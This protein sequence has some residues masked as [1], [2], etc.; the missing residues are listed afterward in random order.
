M[1][2]SPAQPDFV[3]LNVQHVG[4]LVAHRSQHGDSCPLLTQQPP[5]ST[6]FVPV[7]IESR[8]ATTVAGQ[9]STLVNHC[10]PQS[11]RPNIRHR[12]DRHPVCIVII[13]FRYMRCSWYWCTITTKGGGGSAYKTKT[14]I[15]IIN[16]PRFIADKHWN[17]FEDHTGETSERW[18]GAHMGFSE[19]IYHPELN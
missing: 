6:S 8:P 18:S 11:S 10:R 12:L 13:I 16:T 4:F 2:F 17:R 9:R 14:G 19:R 7:A 15:V 1:L 3:V 5:P